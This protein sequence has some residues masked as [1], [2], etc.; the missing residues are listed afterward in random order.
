MKELQDI[1]Y[2]YPIDKEKLTQQIEKLRPVSSNE[3]IDRELIIA[4]SLNYQKIPIL[5]PFLSKKSLEKNQ[6]I[7]NDQDFLTILMKNGI[8]FPVEDVLGL[9]KNMGKSFWKYPSFCFI[10][11]CTISGRRLL[12]HNGN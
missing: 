1:L 8:D 11:N 4:F 10:R 6:F 9:K 12:Y 2:S 3:E 5:I 7:H